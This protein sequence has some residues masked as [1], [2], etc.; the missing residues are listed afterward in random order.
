MHVTMDKLFVLLILTLVVPPQ[1][2]LL[3]LAIVG[4]WGCTMNSDIIE[5]C[6]KQYMWVQYSNCRSHNFFV[7]CLTKNYNCNWINSCVA[8]MSWPTNVVLCIFFVKY[9]SSGIV[10]LSKVIWIKQNNKN[11]SLVE[12]VSTGRHAHCDGVWNQHSFVLSSLGLDKKKTDFPFYINLHLNGPILINKI[13]RLIFNYMPFAGDASP[14]ASAFSVSLKK[15]L[16]FWNYAERKTFATS[17]HYFLALRLHHFYSL[18]AKIIT[19]SHHIISPWAEFNHKSLKQVIQKLHVFLFSIMNQVTGGSLV[20]LQH[21]FS[22]T[23]FYFKA[24]WVLKLKKN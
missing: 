19:I 8:E 21:L 13:Q 11:I 7:N 9:S 1:Q 3:T 4:E 12:L 10:C 17:R 5:M 23:L 16:F 22:Q 20:Q 6:I 15:Y 2:V 24:K 18:D 14:N